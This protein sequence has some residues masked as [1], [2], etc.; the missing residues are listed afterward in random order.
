[1]LGHDSRLLDHHRVMLTQSYACE[2]APKTEA[3][4]KLHLYGLG[5]NVPTLRHSGVT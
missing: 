3:M 2:S 5:S 4:A 1:M